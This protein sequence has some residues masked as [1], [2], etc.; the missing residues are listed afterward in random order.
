MYAPQ[1]RFRRFAEESGLPFQ[2]LVSFG[3]VE[4]AQRLGLIEK[5]VKAV[6]SP[7]RLRGVGQ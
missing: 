1:P 6:W 7:M 2:A 5:L 4:H 3:R